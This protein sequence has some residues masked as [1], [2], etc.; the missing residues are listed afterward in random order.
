[1]F[2]NQSLLLK[3]AL[4]FSFFGWFFNNFYRRYLNRLRCHLLLRSLSGDS[5][6]IV[7]SRILVKLQ[8]QSAVLIHVMLLL[9]EVLN[10]S[11]RDVQLDRLPVVFVSL[12]DLN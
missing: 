2:V 4:A 3:L 6:N 11:L 8:Q 10:F 12:S 7:I 9:K 5:N 1:M